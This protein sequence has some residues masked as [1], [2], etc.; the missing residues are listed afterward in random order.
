MLQG[1]SEFPVGLL[2]CFYASANT[3]GSI[4]LTGGGQMVS[5]FTVAVEMLFIMIDP[6]LQ[7][8]S[9]LLEL[10]HDNSPDLSGCCS[11]DQRS[12]Y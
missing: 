5:Y 2:N 4:R 12:W 8:Y 9:G 7:S 11:P 1:M 6:M 10:I 3:R